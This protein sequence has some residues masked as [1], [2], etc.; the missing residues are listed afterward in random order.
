[1][2][3]WLRCYTQPALTISH[4]VAPVSDSGPDAPLLQDIMNH[5]WFKKQKFKWKDLYAERVLGGG[6]LGHRQPRPTAH[7]MTSTMRP[8]AT[9]SIILAVSSAPATVLCGPATPPPQPDQVRGPPRR[10]P[11]DG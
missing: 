11:Q 2:R 5:Q 10:W 8:A 7:T 4:P 9:T 3:A 1:M 6:E